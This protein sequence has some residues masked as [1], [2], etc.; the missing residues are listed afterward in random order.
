MTREVRD[1]LSQAIPETSG[2]GSIMLNSEEAAPSGCP[3]TT[4][5]QQPKELLQLVDTSSQASAE[6]AEAS[7]EGIPDSMSPIAVTSR[8]ESISPPGRHN[9]AAVQMPTRPSRS[10][11]PPKHL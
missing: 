8:S 6:M 7:L 2:Q 9:G 1:L 3:Y 5:S 10:C 4:P 11:L